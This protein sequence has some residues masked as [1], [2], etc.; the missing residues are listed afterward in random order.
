MHRNSPT[1]P[2][3]SFVRVGRAAAKAHFFKP[4]AGASLCGLLGF[5]LPDEASWGETRPNEQPEALSTPARPGPYASRHWMFQVYVEAEV[6]GMDPAV[7]DVNGNQ[8]LHTFEKSV[9][10]DVT[11][12]RWFCPRVVGWTKGAERTESKVDHWDEPVQEHLRWSNRFPFRKR[13]TI[14]GLP[15]AGCQYI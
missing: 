4:S 3:L 11:L 12:S 15:W 10:T 6:L 13:D 5:E 1:S 8:K 2:C 7:A 9:G 14:R